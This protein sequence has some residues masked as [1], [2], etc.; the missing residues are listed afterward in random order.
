MAIFFLLALTILQTPCCP[1]VHIEEFELNIG[2]RWNYQIEYMNYTFFADIEVVEEGIISSFDQVREVYVL[3]VDYMFGEIKQTDLIGFTYSIHLHQKYYIEKE[4]L[5]TV[6]IESYLS[7]KI[8]IEIVFWGGRVN[9]FLREID[10]MNYVKGGGSTI[11][12]GKSI[13]QKI[14]QETVLDFNVSVEGHEFGGIRS[15]SLAEQDTGRFYDNY[16]NDLDFFGPKD[17]SVP[18]GNFQTQ[19]VRTYFDTGLP[20]YYYYLK[21][22][23]DALIWLNWI[24]NN[25]NE[26]LQEEDPDEPDFVDYDYEDYMRVEQHNTRTKMP[27]SMTD[28]L[29]NEYLWEWTLMDYDLVKEDKPFLSLRSY[30]YFISFG[31]VGLLVLLIVIWNTSVRKDAKP[32]FKGTENLQE[33]LEGLF[34]KKQ[35]A[36]P[37]RPRKSVHEEQ[38]DYSTQRDLYASKSYGQKT[39]DPGY[40][41]SPREQR[42]LYDHFGRTERTRN[43]FEEE[44]PAPPSPEERLRDRLK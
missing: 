34:E 32:V 36:K 24:L 9:L 42:D 17:V 31:V 4:T 11:E 20:T 26:L 25:L 37:R 16:S 1:A 44:Y 33:R 40:Q 2:D 27:V 30:Y 12:E 8:S 28:Y 13:I 22:I 41:I 10:D 5:E 14:E 6:R 23:L 29:G 3:K 35:G 7:T 18:A 43:I 21:Y 38:P 15:E 19:G 39:K